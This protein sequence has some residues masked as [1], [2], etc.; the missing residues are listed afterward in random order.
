MAAEAE[1]GDEIRRAATE[2]LA[3]SY[4]AFGYKAVAAALRTCG[5]NAEKFKVE[6]NA[7]EMALRDIRSGRREA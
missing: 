5:A 2:Y 6:L 7:V 4:E 3:A 1:P